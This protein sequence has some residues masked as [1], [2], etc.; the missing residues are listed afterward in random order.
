MRSGRHLTGHVKSS[1]FGPDVASCAEFHPVDPTYVH[2]PVPPGK[3]APGAWR[4]GVQNTGRFHMG[5]ST[6]NAGHT[7][8]QRV[9]ATTHARARKG[10]ARMVD[11]RTGC[12][13]TDGCGQRAECA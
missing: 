13:S 2:S 7:W 5:D 4:Q 9:K 1:C 12:G 10:L 11:Q 6:F 8:R 3:T